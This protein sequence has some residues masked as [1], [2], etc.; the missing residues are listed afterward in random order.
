[1]RALATRACRVT[2]AS[3][4]HPTGDHVTHTIR[5]D[6]LAAILGVLGATVTW[7]DHP[8]TWWGE[9]PVWWPHGGGKL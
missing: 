7:P 9:A 3:R 5:A 2:R 4:A 1:M 8:P 6:T